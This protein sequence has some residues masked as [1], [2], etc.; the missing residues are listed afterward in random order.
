MAPP[1]RPV[2]TVGESAADIA[3]DNVGMDCY[4]ADG[5]GYYTSATGNGGQPEYWCSDFA[6]WCWN[7]AGADV[8]FTDAALGESELDAAAGKFYLYGEAHNTLSNTPHVGDAV[9]FDY[10]VNGRGTANHVAIVTKVNNDD[11]TIETV[12]GNWNGQSGSMAY[13]SSTSSVVVND[14]DYPGDVDS[15]PGVIG[16]TISGFISPVAK[17][18]Q[19]GPLYLA[20]GPNLGVRAGRGQLL[21]AVAHAST[22]HSGGQPVVTGSQSIF[23]GPD[24][25][26]LAGR[27][28]RTQDGYLIRDRT[29]DQIYMT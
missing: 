2:A 3:L 14:P 13:F 4:G 26:P 18:A 23:V 29:D 5:Q 1:L 11:G 24:Q 9:V 25:S 22:L 8:T 17:Q 6:K 28:D 7:A 12:S 19:E 27:G 16:M 15:T 10:G 21:V 20:Q